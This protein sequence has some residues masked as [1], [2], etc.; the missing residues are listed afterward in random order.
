LS[1]LRDQR[2]SELYFSC[3]QRGLHQREMNEVALRMAAA[4]TIRVRTHRQ[5]HLDAV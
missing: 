4:E 5:Q 3:T 2:S 1:S